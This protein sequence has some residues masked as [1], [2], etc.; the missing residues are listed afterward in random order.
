MVSFQSP[1]CSSRLLLKNEMS[2]EAQSER[3]HAAGQ[4]LRVWARILQ[5]V[6]GSRLLLKNKP[7]ACASARAHTSA[8][9]AAHGIDAGRVRT[10]D[11]T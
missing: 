10:L 6:S 4:V 11:S 1:Y 9:L 5:A 7:Y 8:A 2:I 3:H